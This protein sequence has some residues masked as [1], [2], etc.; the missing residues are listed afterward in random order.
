MARDEINRYILQRH[1]GKLAEN[2]FGFDRRPK[3]RK[4]KTPPKNHH[5][6][7]PDAKTLDRHIAQLMGFLS[8]CDYEAFALFELLPIWLRFLAKYELLD[9]DARLQTIEE[10]NYL[11]G[12]MMLIAKKKVTDPTLLQ[13]VVDWPYDRAEK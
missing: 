11:K 4:R 7:C 9:E 12:S 5:V 8:F 2:D 1:A 6:L 3:R 10:M 13:N